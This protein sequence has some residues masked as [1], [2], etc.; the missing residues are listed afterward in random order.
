MLLLLLHIPV[1]LL[2]FPS[3]RLVLFPLLGP[4]LLILLHQMVPMVTL[5][6]F[7]KSADCFLVLNVVVI[8]IALA[9]GIIVVELALYP[10][11]SIPLFSCCR[12]LAE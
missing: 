6:V 2:P 3:S 1:L 9:F 7:R 5:G 4:L 10:E 8:P 12:W 11:V